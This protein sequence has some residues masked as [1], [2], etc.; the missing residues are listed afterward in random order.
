MAEIVP[1]IL[2][3]DPSDFRK[4]YAELF[5]LSHHFRKLHVDFIDGEFLPNK[6][7]M[8]GDECRLRTDFALSAHLMTYKPENYFAILKNCGYS[9]V[10]VHYEAFDDKEDINKA[11]E[12]AGTLGLSIGLVLNPETD[13]HQ[14]AK[15]V[16]KFRL[17]QLMGVHPG[18]QGKEF[19]LKTLDRIRELKQLKKDAIISVDGGIKPGIAKLCRDAG[20]DFIVVGSAILHSNHPKQILEELVR[21]AL[22]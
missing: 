19:I 8:P 14:A 12:L 1:A 13:L 18:A 21:E 15:F 7:L 5:S 9:E 11:Y 22:T 16:Q 17:L 6:T 2:T 3:N 20:A 10:L 4:K